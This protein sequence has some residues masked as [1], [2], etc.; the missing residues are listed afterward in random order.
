VGEWAD[1]LEQRVLQVRPARDPWRL[2]VL[3]IADLD[4]ASEARARAE[5]G[6]AL[7]RTGF[8]ECE[9]DVSQVF[10]DVRG[11]AVLLEAA[12]RAEEDGRLLAVAPSRSV[13]TMCRALGIGS[14]LRLLDGLCDVPRVD[15]I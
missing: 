4:L 13:L 1:L 2:C 6:G 9:V 12:A 3:A 15:R 14:Q 11:L 8:R 10:V 5:L 7:S